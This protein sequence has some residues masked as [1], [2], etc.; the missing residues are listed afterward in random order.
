MVRE[1]IGP[2]LPRLHVVIIGPGLGRDPS[3]LEGVGHLVDLCR[4]AAKPLVVDADGLWLATLRPDLFKVGTETSFSTF[5][6]GPSFLSAKKLSKCHS[7][8]I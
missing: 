3:V 2:W 5:F 6:M 8:D 4:A 7:E 1:T